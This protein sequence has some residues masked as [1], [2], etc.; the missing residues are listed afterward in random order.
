M[1]ADRMTNSMDRAIST[2]NARRER[3]LAYNEEHGITP[4]GIAKEIFDITDDVQANADM[5]AE[6]QELAIAERKEQYAAE[7]NHMPAEELGRMIK[8]LERQMKTAAQ[9]F[10]FEKAAELRDQIKELREV[11][12]LRRGK[13]KQP[14]AW[15]Q[16]R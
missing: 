3:Q 8:E 16:Y 15:E 6:A 10:E 4:K 12:L 11:E 1:Y 13:G 7:V 2:T 9:V 14:K 5:E